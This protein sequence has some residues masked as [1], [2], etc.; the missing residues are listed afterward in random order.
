MNSESP[1]DESSLTPPPADA[2]Q[3]QSSPEDANSGTSNSSQRPA[4]HIYQHIENHHTFDMSYW[5][6][7]Q[8]GGYPDCLNHGAPLPEAPVYPCSQSRIITGNL[9]ADHSGSTPL[10]G[11]APIWRESTAYHHASYPETC[12]GYECCDKYPGLYT[13]Y[14]RSRN[15]FSS[16]VQQNG[17]TKPTCEFAGQ[18]YYNRHHDSYGMCLPN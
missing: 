18:G 8:F 3:H 1:S 11:A 17:I 10:N 12:P 13:G 16:G 2:K 6:H 9:F 7:L 15:L 14:G 5:S 4:V